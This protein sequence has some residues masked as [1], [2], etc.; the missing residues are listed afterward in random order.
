M[1]MLKMTIC[2]FILSYNAPIV[3]GRHGEQIETV[4]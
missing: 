1:K 2:Q 3:I 4:H